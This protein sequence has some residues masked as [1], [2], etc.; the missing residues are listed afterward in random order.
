MRLSLFATTYAF[1]AAVLV[2]DAN[3]QT[4]PRQFPPGLLRQ[5]DDL[6]AGRF[7]RRIENLPQAARDRAVAWLSQHHVTEE[8]FSALEVDRD[9]GV[10]YIDHFRLPAGE[11]QSQEAPATAQA[12]VP[13]NPLP[14]DVTFHSRPGALN[15]LY[16]DFTGETVS[17][18][19]WN[20]SEDVQSWEA[21]PFSTDS[22]Y[23]T[24]TDS[25]RLAIK[26]I[27]QRV[28][29]DYAPFD[30]DVT[31]ERPAIMT[32]RTAH[33]LI[34]RNTDANGV[35]CP[36]S[37]G[38]GVGYLGVFAGLNYSRYRPVWI[39]HNNLANSEAYTAEATSHEVGHNM[40]LSHDGQNGGTDYYGGHG[41]GETSWGP[42]M[43][44]GYNRNVTQWTMGEYYL[45]NNTQDD[46]AV[47]AGKIGL[48][49]DDH[50]NSISKA[51]ALQVN[52]DGTITSTTP[53]TD[54]Q[55]TSKANKGVIERSLDADAFSFS[56]GAGQVTL[57]VNPW[58]VPGASTR[59]GNVD[60]VLEI[61]SGSGQLLHRNN[62]SSST[63]T[64]IQTNLAAGTYYLIVKPTGVGSPM[65]L[66]A[67][68]YTVY[69]SVGQYFISGSVLPITAANVAPSAQLSASDITTA[70]ASTH[71]FTVQYI[72]D[73]AVSVSTIDSNDLRVTG[74]NGYA[75]TATF[76][77]VD[78]QNNGS[79]RVATYGISSPGSTWTPSNNGTYTIAVLPNAVSDTGGAFVPAGV[80]G[81]F[82]VAIQAPA[83]SAPQ[84]T[85]IVPNATGAR[86]N[87]SGTAG[88]PHVLEITGNL[89]A[90]SPLMTN[91]PSANTFFF[92]TSSAAVNGFYRVRLQ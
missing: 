5:V 37:G 17:N 55:N 76:V 42:L 86:I 1:F 2:M 46:L 33:A 18:T 72:D 8:D 32:S 79:P 69:G 59:G 91:T 85:G 75:A 21:L 68:G 43:G 47:I 29:E 25:E 50:A 92:Q 28:A 81:S 90:W 61:Y 65:S 53:E 20:R 78:R 64:L 19:E 30:I 45:A 77:S 87:V 56:T 52:S 16:L 23:T 26:R 11:P 57:R 48:R 7:K 4:Q 41:S 36:A 24:F 34:T 27:W 71:T 22:D 66:S 6:P 49:M 40:G 58:I 83:P 63:A 10:Y 88:V 67:S 14:A 39:Y 51:T 38:G 74:P 60:L 12:A 70:N 44:T 15:V 54:P 9:G 3:A 31:T 62:P 35:P 82:E 13:I 89:S 80:I 84:I 73:T